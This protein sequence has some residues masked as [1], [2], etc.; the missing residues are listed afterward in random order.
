L[1]IKKHQK[2]VIRKHV[3]GLTIYVNNV[4]NV[5]CLLLFHMDTYV[6]IESYEILDDKDTKIKKKIA[7]VFLWQHM[8]YLPTC[9]QEKME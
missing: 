5:I 8:T 9:N 6:Q 7:Q 3:H 4:E 1:D 2:Y